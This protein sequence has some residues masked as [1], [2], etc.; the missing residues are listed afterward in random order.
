MNFLAPAY[1]WLLAA[2]PLVVA[3]HF[4]R[5]RRR[6]QLVSAA[7]LW[8][9]ARDKAT[10]QRRFAL[11]WLLLLQILAIIALAAALAQPVLVGQGVPDRILVIDAS[12][13]MAARDPDGVRLVK[14]LAA[15]GDLVGDGGRVALIRAG[16]D[17]TVLAP[18]TASEGDLSVALANLEATDASADLDRAL[19]LAAGLG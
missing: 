14:A 19:E 11:W 6:H 9:L 7:F 17:A 16:S 15:A 5:N 8:Q 10:E 1:L 4:L 13:S 12:A 2:I 3:L 18:L